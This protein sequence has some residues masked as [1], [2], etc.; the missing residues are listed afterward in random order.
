MPFVRFAGGPS[1]PHGRLER[2][3]RQTRSKSFGPSFLEG[4]LEATA[5]R[6][7]PKPQSYFSWNLG[8]GLGVIEYGCDNEPRGVLVV[9][10]Q[11]LI[12]MP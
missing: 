4:L 11:A 3:R 10:T 6:A 1:D 5:A 12:C 7:E 8:F 9:A 2:K